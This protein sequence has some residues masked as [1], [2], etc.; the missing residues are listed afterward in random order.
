MQALH[1][2][3]ITL[4][5]ADRAETVLDL[6]CGRGRHLQI[7]RSNA[8]PDSRL[9]GLDASADA[10]DAAREALGDDPRVDLRTHAYFYAIPMFSFVGRRA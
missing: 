9:V 6:G 5:D 1:E 10:L 4:L 3:V 7:L 8:G 2:H